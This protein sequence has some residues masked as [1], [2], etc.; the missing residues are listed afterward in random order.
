ME[1]ARRDTSRPFPLDLGV[2]NEVGG[3][4]GSGDVL[5]VE[6]DREN[7]VFYFSIEEEEK[8]KKHKEYNK[9]DCTSVV[10]S[11]AESHLS[12]V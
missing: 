8:K 9:H 2:N 4:D 11:C 10:S 6:D 5:D 1:R 3:D 7:G 12:W